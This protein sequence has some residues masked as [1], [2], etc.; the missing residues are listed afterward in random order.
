VTTLI[1]DGTFEGLLTAIAR[2]VDG[3]DPVSVTDRD[4]WQPDMFAKP[5]EVTTDATTARGLVARIRH[6]GSPRSFHH[7]CF[8]YLADVPAKGSLILDYLRLL[9]QAGASVDQHVADRAVAEVHRVSR[10]VG[11]EAHRLKGLVRFRSLEDGS[12]WAPISPRHDVLLIVAQHF[13][14][15]L[16]RERWVIH[17]TGRQQGVDASRLPEPRAAATDANEAVYANLW[18]RYF[19]SIAIRERTN[20]KLQRQLMPSRYWSYLTEMTFPPP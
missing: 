13:R 10:E 15:R 2:V 9:M 19:A 11:Q 3:D 14:A 4:A 17:D 8:T 12:L 1:H 20:R 16:P 5:I 6:D 18:R 7:V